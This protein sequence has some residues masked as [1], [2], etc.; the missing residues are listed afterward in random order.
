MRNVRLGGL[1]VRASCIAGG[2]RNCETVVLNGCW[3]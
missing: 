3:N 2:G 1:R